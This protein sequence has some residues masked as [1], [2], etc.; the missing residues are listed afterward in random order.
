MIKTIP[1]KG[2]RKRVEVPPLVDTK[3]SNT[4]S[5]MEM[6]RYLQDVWG[7]TE[8]AVQE[9][10]MQ[11][12]EDAQQAIRDGGWVWADMERGQIVTL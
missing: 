9:R 6:H 1:Y 11:I 10:G 8:R 12:H 5:I 7:N 2:E 3:T 4:V